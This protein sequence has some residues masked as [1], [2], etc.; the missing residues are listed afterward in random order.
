MGPC[1]VGG[2]RM[3]Y[4]WLIKIP[5]YGPILG[6]TGSTLKFMEW[7]STDQRHQV[8]WQRQRV[9]L[10]TGLGPGEAVDPHGHP[11]VGTA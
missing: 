7:P 2:F 9:P 1:F 11:K 3:V 4:N 8:P 5:R 10:K 6:T